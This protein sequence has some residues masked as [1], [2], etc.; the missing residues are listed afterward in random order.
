[1]TTEMD[2]NTK[3]R[4]LAS[5][6]QAVAFVKSDL[7]GSVTPL[8]EILA[9]LSLWMDYTLA[10][11]VVVQSLMYELLNSELIGETLREDAESIFFLMQ[12]IKEENEND[13]DEKRS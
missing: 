7:S 13:K 2:R 5:C 4:L 9:D 11:D 8:E 1:M 6:A 10:T 12:T 3:K